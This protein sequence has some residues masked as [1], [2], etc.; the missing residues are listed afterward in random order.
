MKKT[1]NKG[2][3]PDKYKPEFCDLA[4][5]ILGDRGTMTAL[6]KACKVD[7]DT[8]NAWAKKYPEFHGAIRDGRK[9]G[10]DTMLKMGMEC[11]F[12]RKPFRE[13]TFKYLMA[14]MYGVREKQEIVATT[15]NTNTN[16]NTEAL[17]E[18]AVNRVLEAINTHSAFASK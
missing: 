18:A 3:R 2:G 1:A 14:V 17:D 15:T 13:N 16:H 6:A 9:Q 8:L 5:E 10:K 7:H 4:R 11:A 12:S